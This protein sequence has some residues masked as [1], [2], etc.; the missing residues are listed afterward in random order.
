[1]NEA[2]NQDLAEENDK[3]ARAPNIILHGVNEDESN[4]KDAKKKYDEE[5]ISKFLREIE[6]T[7]S[8]KLISRLGNKILTR[9]VLLKL[10]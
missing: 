5:Y 2:K 3:K 10:S 8:C 6:V 1:M 7:T 9:N 4:D